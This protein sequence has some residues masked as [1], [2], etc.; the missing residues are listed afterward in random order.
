MPW[1]IEDIAGLADVPMAAIGPKMG[2]PS[3]MSRAR[4]DTL[5]VSVATPG[6]RE[7]IP[8]AT[9]A[10]DIVA[11]VP[12][13]ADICSSKIPWGIAPVLHEAGYQRR[14]DDTEAAQGA[15]LQSMRRIQE[16]SAAAVPDTSGAFEK[17]ARL[18]QIIGG[19]ELGPS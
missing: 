19:Q 15:A 11:L 10:G 9:C 3:M 6:Y 2:N 14:S 7:T 16:G 12:R 18:A 5:M 17:G 1:G 13:L 4:Q 8:H